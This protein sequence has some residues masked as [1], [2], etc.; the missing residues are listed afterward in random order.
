MRTSLFCLYIITDG[1]KYVKLFYHKPIV[2]SIHSISKIAGNYL[3]LKPYYVKF[4]VIELS[5]IPV[6][7]LKCNLFRGCLW[8]LFNSSAPAT[9]QKPLPLIRHICGLGTSVGCER[10]E[11]T[12][13]TPRRKSQICLIRGNGFVCSSSNELNRKI[14]LILF[15]IYIIMFLADILRESDL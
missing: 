10:V 2:F 1:S 15:L 6:Q 12:F 9:A 5:K 4:S 13:N 7:F 14:L 11:R 8:L 3:N